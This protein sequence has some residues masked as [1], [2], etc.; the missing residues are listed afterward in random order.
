MINQILRFGL[1]SLVLIL[2]Q[3]LLF[4]NIQFSG[5]VNPYIYLMIILLLP[6][7]MQPWLLLL[8]AFAIGMLIDLTSGTPGVHAA[9][10]VFAA[11]SRPY[12]LRLIAP[13]DGYEAGLQLSM[14]NYGFRWAFLYTI[15]IVLIHHTALFFL[16]VFR[17]N[18]FFRTILRILLSSL[19]TAGF[20]LIAEYYR[21]NR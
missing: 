21:K 20:I 16:E 11:F 15:I 3:M 8:I 14:T 1:I 13:R 17:L 18:G 6:A 7:G 12:V 5:Y 19:F 4:N 2:L 9:A 10:T